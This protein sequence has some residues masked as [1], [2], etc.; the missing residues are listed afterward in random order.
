M[1]KVGNAPLLTAGRSGCAC[2][3]TRDTSGWDWARLPPPGNFSG[4]HHSSSP[5]SPGY[6]VGAAEGVRTEVQ[7]KPAKCQLLEPLSADGTTPHL[8]SCSTPI[9]AHSCACFWLG[10]RVQPVQHT[11]IPDPS[12]PKH[13]STWVVFNCNLQDTHCMDIDGKV[14]CVF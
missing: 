9:P 7:K 1:E 4:N 6:S 13:L 5:S 2:R 3:M 11:P 10:W 8:S 14:L 12:F